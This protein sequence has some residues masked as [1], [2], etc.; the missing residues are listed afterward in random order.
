MTDKDG[1]LVSPSV[2]STRFSSCGIDLPRRQSL[3]CGQASDLS[4][5]SVP[6]K[7]RWCARCRCEWG[8]GGVVK[9]ALEVFEW[10]DSSVRGGLGV[11]ME[12]GVGELEVRQGREIWVSG[13]LAA[14][15]SGDTSHADASTIIGT[16]R[17]SGTFAAVTWMRGRCI[18]T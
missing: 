11:Q 5:C 8:F 9:V 18:W 13:K 16:A 1:I 4:E 14:E 3:Q 17:D 2:P 10:T 7:L 12:A 15:C 6:T